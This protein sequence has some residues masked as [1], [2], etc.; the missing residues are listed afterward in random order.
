MVSYPGYHP[1]R[2]LNPF[3]FGKADQNQR[4]FLG[5]SCADEQNYKILQDFDSFFIQAESLLVTYLQIKEAADRNIENKGKLFS[6]SHTNGSF[7]TF[8]I[9]DDLARDVT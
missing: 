4:I 7:T 1:W 6:S 8:H 2:F 3:F 5:G 9:R